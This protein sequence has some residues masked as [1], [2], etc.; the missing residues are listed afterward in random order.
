MT[1]VEKPPLKLRPGVMYQH[2]SELRSFVEFCQARD[3]RRFLEI[4][5]RWGDSFFAVMANLRPGAVGVCVDLP[6]S[7]EKQ[8]A[9]LR[10]I[11]E[12][13][14]VLGHETHA[15]FGSSRDPTIFRAAASYAPFDLVFIDGDHTYEGV[16]ADWADYHGL[17]PIVVLH[18]VSAPDTWMSDGKLN[19]V[20]RFWRE[21][22]AL[23]KAGGGFQ[24]LIEY[25]L[26]S[27]R[28]MGYGIVVL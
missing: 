28:P 9:V 12:V 7:K 21:L 10:T 27:D 18:D 6:E 14:S 2:M 17:A 8:E 26:P 4:G 13:G 1:A 11:D 19:G 20:G 3:V 16:R 24:E 22:K 25:I 23:D 15:I 5:S